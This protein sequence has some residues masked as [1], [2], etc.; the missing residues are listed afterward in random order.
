MNNKQGRIQNGLVMTQFEVL[1]SICLEG[2]R[3]L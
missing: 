3:Q 1:H 2:L